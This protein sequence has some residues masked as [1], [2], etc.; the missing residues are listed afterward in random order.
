M[1]RLAWVR[2]V[3]LVIAVSLIVYVQSELFPL[4]L[5]GVLGPEGA[6]TTAERFR[7][8]SPAVIVALI[9][10]FYLDVVRKKIDRQEEA[11]SR[12]RQER[13]HSDTLA[14]IDSKMDHLHS[15]IRA[16]AVE[17]I[18]AVELIEMGLG[19]AFPAESRRLDNLAKGIIGPPGAGPITDCTIRHKLVIIQEFPD[20]VV[21]E[22]WQTARWP[23]DR[24]II[25]LT[26]TYEANE[27]LAFAC[28]SINDNWIVGAHGLLDVNAQ[29][30]ERYSYVEVVPS[31][32]DHGRS[33]RCKLER[34]DESES[35]AILGSEAERYADQLIVFSA[36]IPK[37]ADPITVYTQCCRP[38]GTSYL[39][40][41]ADC[42]TYVEEISFDIHD[43]QKLLHGYHF[44]VVPFMGYAGDMEVIE[45]ENVLAS[46]PRNWL[47]KGQGL[48]LVWYSESTD[49]TIGDSPHASSTRVRT[50]SE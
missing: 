7:Q 13:L 15:Q 28:P 6:S 21:I 17:S 38:L 4:T 43:L 5:R 27:W 22:R 32:D 47:L 11:G 46:K 3:F 1:G 16:G 35:I 24:Y 14:A 8:N 20:C 2:L 50:Q 36:N 33:V 26:S 29:L 31:S 30:Q 19:K 45:S 40:W 42:P 41:A 9:I 10:A 23:M 48:I 25:A 39:F 18:S 12:T 37:T 49:G 44:E 34:L